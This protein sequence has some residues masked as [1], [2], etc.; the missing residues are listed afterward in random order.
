MRL[1]LYDRDRNLLRECP[2]ICKAMRGELLFSVVQTAEF[3]QFSPM[4]TLAT[5]FTNVVKA[6]TNVGE[7]GAQ[8]KLI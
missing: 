5:L 6:V 7:S 4:T 1:L 2:F 8:L 3:M